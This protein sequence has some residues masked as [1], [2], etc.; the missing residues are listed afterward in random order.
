MNRALVSLALLASLVTSCHRQPPD[1]PAEKIYRG[2]VQ[3][4]AQ[5]SA[6]SHDL[7]YRDP[8]FDAVLAELAKVPVGSEFQPE[9]EALSTRIRTA[10]EKANAADAESQRAIDQAL[11]QPTFQ[12]QGKIEA[13]QGSVVTP[14][15]VK[16]ATTPAGSAAVPGGPQMELPSTAAARAVRRSLAAGAQE[17]P[18]PADR[19]APET[20]AT[21]QDEAVPVPEAA[22]RRRVPPAPP[23]PPPT[24]PGQVFGLPGPAGRAMGTRP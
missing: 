20:E 14:R 8:R 16:A 10:R 24:P 11:A 1:D 6:A 18:D 17:E 21:A 19:P 12:S 4:F 9:A 13:T 3:L 5:A 22:P 2:A 23:P 7:T 15:G